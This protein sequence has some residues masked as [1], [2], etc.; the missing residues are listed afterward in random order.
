ML[1]ASNLT[2][3]GGRR[4]LLDSVTVAFA[5]GELTA[6]VGPNGAGKT[7]LLRCLDGELQPA[8]GGVALGGRA[9]ADWPRVELA[10]AR[11]VLPQESTL[12]FPFSALD[13]V[14]LGRI[15]HA[16]GDAADAAI[17]RRALALCDCAGFA[18][19][20]YTSLSGGEKQ[21]VQTARVLAQILDGVDVGD[22]E[23]DG[24]RDGDGDGGIDGD[25][26]LAAKFLLLDEPV[27]AL[28][29]R[30]QYRLL[31]LLKRLTR[32]GLGVITALHNLNLVAQ[33]AE[34]AL[35]IDRG[36]LVADGAPLEV[37]TAQTL[38]QVFA[39]DVGV[40]PHPDDA[41]LPL[42]LPK[43]PVAVD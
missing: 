36:R 32:A 39:L 15:P 38:S 37:F 12:N 20:D 26:E 6:L 1:R 11:A 7:T 42:L 28:D 40:H 23:S 10:R 16:T 24:D 34:R 35:L 8:A 18:E 43:L 17:A 30:H 4:A 27:S 29:L 2:V 41:T 21:R 14:L 22:G 13:V 25:G 31:D 19:R 5:P 9:L 3:R 33:F